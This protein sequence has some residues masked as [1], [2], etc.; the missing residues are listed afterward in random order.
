M[1]SRYHVFATDMFITDL[2]VYRATFQI[3]TIC[4]LESAFI[5]IPF[6]PTDSICFCYQHSDL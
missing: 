1:Y 2:P 6:K 4:N 5:F 3:Q